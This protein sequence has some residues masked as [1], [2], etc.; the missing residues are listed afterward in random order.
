MHSGWWI[1]WILL[2]C[3]ENGWEWITI[4]QQC[5]S[6][7]MKSFLVI[8]QTFHRDRLIR[9]VFP[10]RRGVIYRW[11]VC[12]NKK[13]NRAKH[14]RKYHHTM[15]QTTFQSVDRGIAARVISTTTLYIVRD[16][17]HPSL[18]T[19]LSAAR[20]LEPIAH[21]ARNRP[22]ACRPNVAQST[23]QVVAT[24]SHVS[25]AHRFL[26]PCPAYARPGAALAS[27]R[28]ARRHAHP[29]R[30]VVELADLVRERTQS[31]TLHRPSPHVSTARLYH[32]TMFPRARPTVSHTRAHSVSNT[33]SS[34]RVP[35]MDVWAT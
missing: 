8:Y 33:R 25:I 27:R 32:A 10:T 30:L 34:T 21:D 24:L 13:T 3:N 2:K 11:I 1:G 18:H 12:S 6:K 14:Q 19:Q 23:P 7:T 17:K 9:Q 5:W 20:R 22:D 29:T 16:K 28:R 15:N 26:V 31:A 4:S 35:T